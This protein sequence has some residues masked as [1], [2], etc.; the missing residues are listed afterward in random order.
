MFCGGK[1]SENFVGNNF[2]KLKI[3]FLEKKHFGF[4]TSLYLL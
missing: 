4:N 2:H 1:N 3:F